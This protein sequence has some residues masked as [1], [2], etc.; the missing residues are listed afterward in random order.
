MKPFIF[1]VLVW[2]C[3]S[4]N[5]LSQNTPKSIR[6]RFCTESTEKPFRLSKLI[7]TARSY[8]K[9]IWFLNDDKLGLDYSAC[10][11]NGDRTLRP[12]DQIQNRRK[13]DLI[14]LQSSANY[15]SEIN[16]SQIGLCVDNGKVV[17]RNWTSNMDALVLI[18][19]GICQVYD[20][21]QKNNFSSLGL[22]GHLT[23]YSFRSELVAASERQKASLFQ[24]HL[25][26]IN[27][28]LQ[29]KPTE[30]KRLAV[31]KLQC[32]VTNS[33]QE[34]F[35]VF[36]YID[37]GDYLYDAARGIKQH[38]NNQGYSIDYMINLDTGINDALELNKDLNQ[39]PGGLPQGDGSVKNSINLLTVYYD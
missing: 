16:N 33:K 4:N 15:H 26:V 20:T 8:G 13:G 24:T 28:S 17:N 2:G 10:Q 1:I 31:R 3:F 7:K 25:L 32:K 37:T 36:F 11:R 18:K 14:L 5:L 38:L 29:I 12:Y 9:G 30:K 19:D 23:Y 34:Q 21:R 35:L 6:E 27:N 39:C 22:S